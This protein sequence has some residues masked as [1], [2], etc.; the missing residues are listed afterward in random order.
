ME[1]Y[2]KDSE[3]E[4]F[5]QTTTAGE[6]VDLL[7]FSHLRWDF[8]TQRPQ[9]LLRRAALSRRVFFWEEPV[10]HESGSEAVS[11]ENGAVSAWL[12]ITQQGQSLWVIKP[13]LCAGVDP[14]SVQRDLLANLLTE[15]RAQRYDAWFYTPMALNFADRLIPEVTVY[16]CM[17][18]LS[19]FNG[20]PPAIVSCEKELFRRADVVFT[21]GVS[22]Y[23]AKRK[24][25]RNVHAFPSSIDKKHFE[26]ALEQGPSQPVDQACIPSPRAGFYGV[27]DERFDVELL[28][29]LARLRPEVH[30]VII[31]PVLKIDRAVLPVA[32]N[33]HYLGPKTYEELPEYLS[34]WD[35]ALLLFAL[36]DATKFISPTKTPEYLA[37]GKPVVS[38]PIRDVVRSYG[39]PGLVRIA[40]SAEEFARELDEAL[41]PQSAEWRSA[42]ASHLAGDSWD[43]TWSAMRSEMEKVR[44][45]RV[46]AD[47]PV[48]GHYAAH[49]APAGV[50]RLRL[51]GHRSTLAAHAGIRNESFDFLV[52]G[53]GFAG[54]VL[55]ERLASQSGKRV[56]LVDRRDHI[57]GNAFDYLDAAGVLV[58]KYGPHIFHTNSEAVFTYLSRF[59]SWR[60][61]EHRVLASVDNLLLPI[62]INLDTVNRLYGLNLDARGMEQ[63]LAARAEV[64][65]LLRTSEDI[66]VSRV[67][68]EL[69]QKF[70][71]N[72]TRKQWGLDPSQLDA[73]VAGRIPVRT[74]RDDRYFTD[75]FQFMPVNGYTRMFEHMLAHPK[76]TVRLGVEYRDVVRSYPQAKVVFTGPIDEYYGFR[77]GALP[78]RSLEFRHETHDRP[79]FQ[80]APVVNYPNEQ[81]Y[82]RI[83]EFKYLT[84][85]N[86]A[87]TSIVYEYPKATGDPYYPIPRSENAELYAKYRELAERDGNVT[88]CGRLANYKYFNM[89]QVVAQALQTYKR[90]EE[91]EPRVLP[92]FPAKSELLP[93][94][95]RLLEA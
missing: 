72:Y 51:E 42:V 74:D 88:F 71:Q 54:S 92:A 77:Y 79:V 58:H 10:W 59:T 68:R 73:A 28:A 43:R 63:F 46:A 66:V 85:Q 87:K 61:Y 44:D 31:G 52:V 90:M 30:F 33:I 57:G 8:V 75:S 69:Y 86:H 19:H 67:G 37:A 32:E 7:C 36:N 53:A 89:D 21:G 13:H 81:E 49:V 76:I 83:T 1:G 29:T 45:T 82:T 95:E 11:I 3:G 65:T 93:L 17:D 25:H 16:D 40:R 60:P 27:V 34:G 56:L 39:D 78:Y 23:E 35:V 84:G 22:L 2:S 9:H 26:R 50:A 4:K 5:Y 41:K 20:A 12:E 6:N 38:T 15:Q 18:E 24:Q 14:D 47:E 64:R 91:R 94:G 48:A 62:P 55:A 70:F 80:Q